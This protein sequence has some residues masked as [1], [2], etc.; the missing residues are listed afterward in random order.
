MLRII[1]QLLLV[2]PA[3]IISPL[4]LPMGL[5]PFSP[6]FWDEVLVGRFESSLSAAL[7]ACGAYGILALPFAIFLPL[8][9]VRKKTWLRVPLVVALAGGCATAVYTFA[10][11][12]SGLYDWQ[13]NLTI[14][15]LYGGPLIVGKRPGD[16]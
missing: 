6:S 9:W 13:K 8:E 4:A 7:L 16:R 14:C 2:L 3:L 1:C 12:R 11:Y 15:W 10:H 5:I